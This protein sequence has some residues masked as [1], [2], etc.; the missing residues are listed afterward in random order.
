ML[1]STVRRGR[2]NDPEAM[3]RRVL[4]VA[5][6]AFQTR[7]YHST[8][9]HDIMREAGVTGGALHHHFPTK[10]ALGLAVIRDRVAQQV[11]ETWIEPIRTA[12]TAAAGIRKVFEQIA[13]T[14]DARGTVLGC[15]L[16][17]LALELSLADPEFQH[18]VQAVFERWQTVIAEKLR[19]DQAA[20]A[21]KKVDPE[22]LATFIVAAYSG[23]MAMAKAKQSSEPLATCAQ[24]LAA[25]VQPGLRRFRR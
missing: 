1:N 22:D 24:Q 14:I 20:G 13:A 5:T 2:S 7:G 23:A 15:P 12:P 21:L 4:D 11:E 8:S 6:A 9:T 3:R 10:K 19:A 16:N 25:F 17:N 18:A